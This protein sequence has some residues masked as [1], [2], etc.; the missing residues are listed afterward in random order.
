MQIAKVTTEN[1]RNGWREI[2]SLNDVATPFSPTSLCGGDA[3]QVLGLEARIR[4]SRRLVR[5][6]VQ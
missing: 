5:R 6:T 2:A 4:R 1:A 3:T